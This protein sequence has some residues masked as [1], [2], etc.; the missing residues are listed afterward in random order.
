MAR[1]YRMQQPMHGPTHRDADNQRTARRTRCNNR[2]MD[3]RAN[4][5]VAP[6]VPSHARQ[7]RTA[8]HLPPTPV[9][10]TAIPRVCDAEQPSMARLYQM[11]QPTHGPT[12][13]DATTS[14]RPDAH[15]CNHRHMD[16]RANRRV[17]PVVPSHAR[18]PRNARPLAPPPVIRTAIPRLC[19]ADHPRSCQPPPNTLYSATWLDCCASWVL[20]SDLRA[21]YAV[22]RASSR[23]R[24]LSRPAS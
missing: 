4:R 7:P 8:R 9:M 20:T 14:A 1:L 18:Q 5:R 2:H 23:V 24:K 12:H 19:G 3:A 15:G 13:R 10:R 21:V 22:R 6:V 16:A 17:A 11:R